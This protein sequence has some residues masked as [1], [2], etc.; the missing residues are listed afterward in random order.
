MVRRGRRY[1]GGHGSSGSTTL[2]TNQNPQR[3]SLRDAVDN[4]IKPRI[5]INIA[6]TRRRLSAIVT[7]YSGANLTLETALPTTLAGGETVEPAGD[8]T[9][10][11]GCAGLC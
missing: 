1:A 5:A 6:G 11:G 2:V 4:G 10:R 7:A 8:N 9:C 3:Q